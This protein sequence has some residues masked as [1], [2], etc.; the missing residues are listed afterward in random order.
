MNLVDCDK[1]CCGCGACEAL[2][3]QAA[4]SMEE[5]ERGFFYPKINYDKC[6]RCGKCMKNCGYRNIRQESLKETYVAVSMSTNPQESASGGVAASLAEAVIGRAGI[7]YGCALLCKDGKM[8][9]Q[10]IRV[11]QAKELYLL[12]GSKYVQS[13]TAGIF[14]KVKQDL[15][16]KEEVLFIGTPCQI[17]GL[18]G[19]LH[20]E[21]Q[22]LYTVDIVCHGVPSIKLFQQY[23]SY[24]ENKRGQK[25]IDFKFRDKSEGW[26]LF[27]KLSFQSADG[28]IT[29]E[30]TEPEEL[31]YYQMFLNSYTYR[32]N[33][34]HCPY[35]SEKRQGDLTIGDYWCIDLVHPGYLNVN[36][37]MIDEKKGVSC[38]VINTE[39]GRKLINEYGKGIRLWN[40]TYEQAAKYNGQLLH[41]AQLRE[42]RETIFRLLEEG[43]EAVEIW[44]Q[45]R[46]KKIRL[47]RKLRSMVPKWIKRGIRK[48]YGR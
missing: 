9:P 1:N 34:Y 33:C 8:M 42:E 36:G 43:Y 45:K 14:Q 25:L 21:Y 6:I 12:K 22:N 17:S 31:S 13:R 46:L 16:N 37:G 30:L 27:A 10:H 19:F 7:V 18:K 39:H 35:A 15:E 48:I 38:V 41:P 4:I 11:T 23:V 29:E 40:S 3:P 47:K 28:R 2:C 26:K 24:L 32:E 44:Y 5:D 20:R